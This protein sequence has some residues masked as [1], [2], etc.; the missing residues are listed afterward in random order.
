MMNRW[1]L[2]MRGLALT[3]TTGGLFAFNG[4]GLSDQQ[5]TTIWQSVITSGLNTLVSSL[6]STGF[7]LANTFAGALTT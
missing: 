1:Y 2:G 5:L 4:C 7:T 3:M 6:I